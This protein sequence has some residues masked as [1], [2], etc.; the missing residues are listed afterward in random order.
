MIL[1][2]LTQLNSSNLE[3]VNSSHGIVR[4]FNWS[5]DWWYC[6]RSIH[7]LCSVWIR[8]DLV[9]LHYRHL[10]TSAQ[11]CSRWIHRYLH[12][13]YFP[14]PRVVRINKVDRLTKSWTGWPLNLYVA[15]WINLCNFPINWRNPATAS[16][17][18]LSCVL[19][20]TGFRNIQWTI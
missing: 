7:S 13:I 2:Y 10:N 17:S 18:S 4:W 9:A 5:R 14:W 3:V 15:C 20:L 8:Y 12:D 6:N 11:I 16:R 19:I 1:Q